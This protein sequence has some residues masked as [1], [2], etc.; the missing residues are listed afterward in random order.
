M[1]IPRENEWTVKSSNEETAAVEM[2]E[3]CIQLVPE[4]F[5]S[6]TE[7]NGQLIWKDLGHAWFIFLF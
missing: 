2:F 7:G 5:C 4:H 3:D 6:Y 1:L